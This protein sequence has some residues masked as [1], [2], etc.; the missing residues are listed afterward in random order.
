M[1]VGVGAFVSA[2]FS[3]RPRNLRRASSSSTRLTPLDASAEPGWA[4]ATTSATDAQSV[5][6]RDGR[7]RPE[8]RRHFDRGNQSRR[9]ARSGA[10]AP[11]PFR[12]A[13]RRRPRRFQRPREILEVHAR[14]K[15]LGREVSLET[16]LNGRRASRG[17]S[18][19]L[20]NEAAL[21]A[22][23]RN[24]SVIEMIDWTRRSTA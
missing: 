16:L 4:A 18:G 11:G 5:A 3:I 9:R 24:K 7:L 2:N 23:R 15:P 21:L 20:L 13:D 22:A 14:N 8:H 10:A 12:T 17:G 1:F 6:R 19:E